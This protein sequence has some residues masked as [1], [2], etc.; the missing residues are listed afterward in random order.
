MFSW[1]IHNAMTEVSTPALSNLIAA[2]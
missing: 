2:E 1:P